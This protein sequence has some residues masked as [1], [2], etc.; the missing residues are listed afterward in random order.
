[1]KKI[2]IIVPCYNE[3]GNIK[4]FYDE[5]NE[6]FKKLKYKIEYIFIND[7]SKDNTIIKLK[8]LLKYKK[9]I[10]IINFS[11][12]F[13]KEA[14][15]YAGL[16]KCSGDYAVLIDADLQQPPRLILPMLDEIEKDNNIDIVAYYQ[17]KRIEGKFISFFKSMFYKIINKITGLNFIDGASDFRLFNRNVINTILE[18]TDQ[19]RFQKGIFAYI[20]FNTKY[21]PYI[22]DERNAGKTSWNFIKLL[23][24]ALD[25][26]M[27]FTNFPLKIS[28][29][30]GFLELFISTIW[31]ILLL[32]LKNTSQVQ[33]IC[34]FILLLSSLLFI[35]LGIISEYIYRT[36]SESRK[37]PIYI[38]KEFI[39]N[40]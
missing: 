31:F 22:P 14:A 23:K 39:D 36:Y 1:M 27:S 3:E 25:G 26:I 21:L 20:G 19:N 38:I 24:Y 16:K 32:V 29:Y 8:D 34:A 4:K 40:E 37:R 17:E 28:S 15:V 6:A 9:D 2:S 5:A 18:F 12:N 30:L 11:R 13:G 35:V 7:G 10:K 33:Y